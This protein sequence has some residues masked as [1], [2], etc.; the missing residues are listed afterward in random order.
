MS[1]RETSARLDA[2]V[3][4]SLAPVAWG[5]SFLYLVFAVAHTR[6][7]TPALADV[8]VPVA[9]GTSLL[10][11]ATAMLLMRFPRAGRYS[12]AVG[13]GILLLVLL[14][15]AL[16]LDLSGDPAQSTNFLLLIIG[17][18]FLL[19]RARWMAGM[20]A[21]TALTWAGIARRHGFGEEWSHFAFALLSAGMVAGL[22][23]FVR[24]NMVLRLETI[25]RMERRAAQQ[26]ALER[27]RFHNL[28]DAAFE[29]IVIHE[30]GTIVD[31]NQ[32]AARMAG[33][34]PEELMGRP[35][36]ELVAPFDR[37]A[38]V[39][40]LQASPERPMP[41]MALRR[42][43][44]TFPAEI[45]GRDLESSGGR[46][47]VLALWDISDRLKAERSQDE[48]I[49]IVSHELRTPLTSIRG[50]ISLLRADAVTRDAAMRQKML[51][52]ADRN[53]DRLLLLIDDLLDLQRL[54]GG[55][56]AL[57]HAVCDAKQLVMQAVAESWPEAD[58]TGVRLDGEGEPARL[59]ADPGRVRQVLG[60]LIR[61]AIKFSGEGTT[62]RVAC[63]VQGSHVLFTVRDEGR[64]IPP[65][66]LEAIFERFH[67][68]DRSDARSVAGTGLGLAICRAIVTQHQ[69]R[70]WAESGERGSTFFVSLP[71]VAKDA[72]GSDEFPAITGT[73]RR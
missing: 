52:I 3:R 62:V 36:L 30:T 24:R 1:P 55:Q 13:C 45:Q 28:A 40:A 64:G 44:S 9:M 51:A 38:L 60:H 16:H 17:A 31:C 61:N 70:I 33:A 7:L 8:M 63:A 26:A 11:A 23:F 66:R 20:G 22:A 15:S 21:I 49:A 10:L 73:S 34:A 42:D 5:L 12:H 4:A 39:Q 59:E 47:R 71:R 50:A 32:Q 37:E 67:Q 2:T 19:L 57:R 56:A 46:L 53:S 72:S 69:G 48:F 18:S 68:V 29:G 6:I 35:V 14:N 41:V 65:D 43:G 27:E 25:S 58:R 54:S